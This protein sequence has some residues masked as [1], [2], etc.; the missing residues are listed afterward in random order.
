MDLDTKPKVFLLLWVFT[1]AILLLTLLKIRQRVKFIMNDGASQQQNEVL[2][3]LK[4]VFP[5]A[6]EGRCRWHISKWMN[7]CFTCPHD[8]IFSQ[9]TFIFTHFT[10]VI[11]GQKVHAGRSP[12]SPG[13]LMKWNTMVRKIHFGAYSWLIPH[14]VHNDKEYIISKYQLTKLVYSKFVLKAAKGN[15]YLVHFIHVF[16]HNHIYVHGNLY[17]YFWQ[18]MIRHFEI[19]HWIPHYIHCVRII[20]YQNNNY[21]RIVLYLCELQKGTKL[22]NKETQCT[23]VT[24]HEYWH[25]CQINP[26][27]NCRNRIGYIPGLSLFWQDLVQTTNLYTPLDLQKD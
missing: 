3:A 21:N 24:N 6:I 4:E 18:K 14:Y 11:E 19:S 13:G 26:R 15:C 22:W 10:S 23:N 8:Y 9:W 12:V 1:H 2:R 5:N 7:Q 17:L 27:S 16:F 20:L 25:I